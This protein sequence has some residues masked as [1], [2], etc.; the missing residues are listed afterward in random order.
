MKHTF[1]V[2]DSSV[3]SVLSRTFN[4][5]RSNSNANCSQS[6]TFARQYVAKVHHFALKLKNINIQI[7]KLHLILK[8]VYLE[9][10][11][12]NFDL[13]VFNIKKD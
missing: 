4:V 3:C 8:H 11:Y 1:I 13:K 2:W 12:T 5:C 6:Y 10:K 7:E 9:L